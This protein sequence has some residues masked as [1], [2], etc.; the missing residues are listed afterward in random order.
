MTSSECCPIRPSLCPSSWPIQLLGTNLK[1]HPCLT[2]LSNNTVPNNYQQAE[3]HIVDESMYRW[4]MR[5]IQIPKQLPHPT[6]TG[7]FFVS[8][9][10]A[11]QLQLLQGHPMQ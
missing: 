10:D 8:L 7:F 3:E 5:I 9:T 1:S 4:M 6:T 11:S 2:Y